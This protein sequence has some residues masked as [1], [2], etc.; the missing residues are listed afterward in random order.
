MVSQFC[1][2]RG[3]Y[4]QSIHQNIPTKGTECFG[5]YTTK[6]NPYND[7]RLINECLVNIRGQMNLPRQMYVWLDLDLGETQMRW[8]R[9]VIGL[10]S[11]DVVKKNNS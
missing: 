11:T 8:M 5:G 4:G 3:S 9:G 10:D 2:L 7:V 6:I 1:T